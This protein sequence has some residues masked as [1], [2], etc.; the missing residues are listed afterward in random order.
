MIS[1]ST[2][3]YD[4]SETFDHRA[5]EEAVGPQGPYHRRVEV[6]LALMLVCIGY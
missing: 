5:L 2:C 1:G 3:Y 6:V 4:A